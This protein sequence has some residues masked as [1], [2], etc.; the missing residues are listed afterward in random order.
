[1]TSLAAGRRPGRAAFAGAFADRLLDLGASRHA[2]ACGLLVLLSL[3]CFL[4]GFASLQPMDRDEPRFAQASKQMLESRDLVDIRFQGEARHKKPVGIYWAQSAVVA[5]A[6]ALGVPAAR[7]TIALYRVP[8]LLGAVATVLLSYWAA[9]AFLPRRQ[10]FLAAALVGACAMLSAEARLAKT[11]A[12]LTA[13]AVAAMGALARAWLGRAAGRLPWG[14]VLAF[15]LALAAGILIKGPMV[16]M[17]AGLAAL[18]LSASARSAAWLRALRPGL[19]LAL[20][21]ALVAPWFVAIA[22]KSGGAFYGEAVGHDMLGKVGTAQTQHWAPPGTYLL[23]VFATF[24]PAAAFAAMALPFA[25]AHRREDGVA[26]LIAWVLPSW[27]VFE[28]VPTKLPHYVLPLCPA[29]AI[30]AVLAVARGGVHRGRPGARAV[31]LLVPLVPLGLTLGLCAAAW[32]LD[33]VLPL[34]G[35]PLLLAATGVAA[36]AWRAFADGHTERALAVSVLSGA[37]LGPAVFGL[38]QPA[39]ASLKVSPRLAALREAVPCPGPEVATLGYREPS[40][41]FL[42][43]TDLRMLDSGAEAAAFLARGGCRLLYVEDR[44]AAPFAAAA[45]AAAATAAGA[46]GAAPPRA[47]GRV[48]GFNIN[49]GKPVGLTAYAVTP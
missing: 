24:W 34:A 33:G 17:F 5:A 30:L 20:V 29:L 40:L 18:A 21:L 35:L 22:L 1:M 28:A 39:L 10:A 36:L 8:S 31:A 46:A 13:A 49:G 4:P 6:E 27:L 11:D 43:G 9:L 48:T 42:T 32:R 19:G 38:T 26:F 37:L 7:T 25:F 12:L 16:P 44:H 15:W 3:A 41:V 45:A 2:L 14:T 23:V 47:V